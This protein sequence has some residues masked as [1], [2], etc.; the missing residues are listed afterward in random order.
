LIGVLGRAFV[1]EGE[2]AMRLKLHRI[3]L[4]GLMCAAMAVLGCKPPPSKVQF[5]NRIAEANVGLESAGRAYRRALFP[6]DGK[7]KDF[8]PDKVKTSEV[9]SALS[10]MESAL[11]DVKK[12]YED[13]DL[14]RRSSAAPEYR[15]AYIEYLDVQKKIVDKAKEI[16]NVL[17]DADKKLTKTEKKDKVDQ[18]LNEIR[19]L[20]NTAFGELEKA[21]KKYA[22]A[23]FFK[24]VQ[25]ID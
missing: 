20:E 15:S 7:G 17:D 12:K 1:P 23:H 25:K 3:V 4:L 19:D 11:N 21:Q 18:L 16:L 14:P 9:Q 24:M 10:G 13:A 22:D 2:T 6:P 5:N 8:D